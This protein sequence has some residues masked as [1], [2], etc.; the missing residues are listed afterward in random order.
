M[1][2]NNMIRVKNELPE[3][4]EAVC[5]HEDCPDW[6]KDAIW[7]AFNEQNIGVSFTASWWRH[8]LESMDTVAAAASSADV[9]QNR[10][11][12]PNVLGFGGRQ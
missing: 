5:H 6:L 7:D 8:M 9:S 10:Y 1:K 12:P 11:L 3:L 4:L 2:K